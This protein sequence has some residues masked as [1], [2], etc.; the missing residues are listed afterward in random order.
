MEKFFKNNV[1]IIVI[2]CEN[3]AL[4]CNKSGICENVVVALLS[5]SILPR[6]GLVPDCY[7]VRP[8]ILRSS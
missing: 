5:F 8:F 4:Q 3:S 6:I 2:G 7:A 1:Q